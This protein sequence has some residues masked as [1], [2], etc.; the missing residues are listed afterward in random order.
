[1]GEPVHDRP[2]PLALGGSAGTRRARRAGL[3][4]AVYLVAYFAMG[5]SVISAGQF[6]KPFGVTSVATGFGIIIALVVL[7]GVAMI[8]LK[9]PRPRGPPAVS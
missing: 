5:V 4:S 8:A 6:V 1:M 2:E 3:F 7:S 9:A